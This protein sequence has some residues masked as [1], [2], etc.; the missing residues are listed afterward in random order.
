MNMNF[1]YEL[2]T[3]I[4]S[5]G[6]SPDTNVFI[7]KL[8]DTQHKLAIKKARIQSSLATAVFLFVFGWVSFSQLNSTV[9]EGNYYTYEDNFEQYAGLDSSSFDLYVADMALY[10]LEEEDDVLSVLEFF[11][12]EEY[13]IAFNTRQ[14]INL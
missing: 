2:K 1:E 13:E 12:E 3:A 7:S 8:H 4:Q 6:N 5:E 11:Q 10:L 14:E 9:F